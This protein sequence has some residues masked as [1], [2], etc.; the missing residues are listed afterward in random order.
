MSPYPSPTTYPS[1][2]LYPGPGLEPQVVQTYCLNYEMFN[3]H[4][5]HLT[6]S[7]AGWQQGQQQVFDVHEAIELA[8]EGGTFSVCDNAIKAALDRCPYVMRV[9]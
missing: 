3:K 4:A 7:Y 8:D 9:D 6:L 2:T 1:P 5:D